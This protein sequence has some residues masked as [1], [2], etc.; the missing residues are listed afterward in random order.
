M[1]TAVLALLALLAATASAAAPPTP[2]QPSRGAPRTIRV[3][4]EGHASAAPDVGVIS[5]G[6]EA[7]DPSLARATA[8]ANERM[9]RV[10]AAVEAAGVAAKDV[11]TTRYDVAIERP[12]QDGKPGPITGYRVSTAAEA[13]VRDLG[14]LGEVVDRA[15]AAGSNAVSGLRL[16][17]AD[18]APE[19]ARALAAAFADAR[20]RAEALARAAGVR[21]GDV[22]SIS[23]AGGGTPGPVPRVMRAEVS[24][25]APIATGELEFGASVEV[26]FAIR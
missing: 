24:G 5:L 19:R 6:V 25:G 16:D 12:W 14:R 1:R 3:D 23:E 17:R 21:L 10:L 4:G 22:V 13:R 7:V 11:R 2:V 20:E 9:H 8:D 26:V 18:P 15:V